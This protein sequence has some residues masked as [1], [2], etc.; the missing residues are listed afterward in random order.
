MA[1][2]KVLAKIITD[3]FII[4]TKLEN[5][6][7]VPVY[8][9]PERVAIENQEY[10]LLPSSGVSVVVIHE[11]RQV[12]SLAKN[13]NY[14]E[15]EE[16][17]IENIS[18]DSLSRFAIELTSKDISAIELQDELLMYLQSYKSETIQREYGVS[19]ARINSS[20]TSLGSLE[21]AS[22][23]NRFRLSLAMYHGKSI[24]SEVDYI[25]QINLITKNEL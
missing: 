2:I 11:G 4:G 23:L 5:G 10:N 17:L 3:T 13:Y 6:V 14:N 8:I 18:Q 21:G 19:L 7:S 12:Y 15:A 24:A 16:K 22:R 1:P 20:W 9:A 25:K